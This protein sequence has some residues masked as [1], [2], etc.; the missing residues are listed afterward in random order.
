MFLVTPVTPYDWIETLATFHTMSANHS[1]PLNSCYRTAFLAKA[2]EKEADRGHG[3][4]ILYFTDVVFSS[5]FLKEILLLTSQSEICTF[6][7]LCFL[8]K[9]NNKRKIETT[10]TFQNRLGLTI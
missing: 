8:E 4:S 3:M 2:R 1:R 10:T 5:S 6:L 9:K 7:T